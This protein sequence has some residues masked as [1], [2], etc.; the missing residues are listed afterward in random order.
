MSPRS[1][2]AV[3][4]VIVGSRLAEAQA[5]AAEALLLHSDREVEEMVAAMMRRR[6]PEEIGAAA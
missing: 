4:S 6:F 2:P 3:R 5:L 1:I